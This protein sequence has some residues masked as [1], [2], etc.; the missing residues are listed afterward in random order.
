M[1]SGGSHMLANVPHHSTAVAVA[2]WMASCIFPGDLS[3]SSEAGSRLRPRAFE[4]CVLHSAGSIHLTKT[5]VRLRSMAAHCM[6][7]APPSLRKSSALHLPSQLLSQ[8]A[9]GCASLVAS[10]SSKQKHVTTTYAAATETAE[11]VRPAD[12]KSS[13]PKPTAQQS[14]VVITGASSGLGL[15]ATKALVSTGMA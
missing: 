6:H 7:T 12:L 2:Q 10:R 1:E 13:S 4:H 3:R 9:K 14:T 5:S 8:Q 15:A 11:A